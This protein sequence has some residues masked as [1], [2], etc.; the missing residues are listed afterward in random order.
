M[1]DDT[2]TNPDHDDS[3]T[4]EGLGDDTTDA[5]DSLIE[6]D[7]GPPTTSETNSQTSN[8]GPSNNPPPANAEHEDQEY[9][10]EPAVGSEAPDDVEVSSSW[11][12]PSDLAEPDEIVEADNPHTIRSIFPYSAGA[13]FIVFAMYL[14]TIIFTGRAD[15]FINNLVPIVQVRAPESFILLPTLALVI[16]AGIILSEYLRRNLTWFI[17]TDDAIY[18]R[19]HLIFREVSDFH[20]TD[21][22][23]I[24]QSDPWHLRKFGVGHI[25]IYTASTDEWEARLS[26]VPSPGKFREA[27]REDT[28]LETEDGS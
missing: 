18:I 22:T 17:V 1:P 15:T 16:G 7:P 8:I 25:L 4:E 20:S 13:M 3:R 28:D 10:A 21:I 6:A 14:F 2:D 19:R 11:F 27:I 12:W 5:V 26:F 9:V 24:S 23:K